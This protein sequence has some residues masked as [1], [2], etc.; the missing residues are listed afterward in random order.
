MKLLLSLLLTIAIVTV[1]ISLSDL[2][3]QISYGQNVLQNFTAPKFGISIQYPVDWTFVENVYEDRDYRPGEP[4][5]YLGELC[6]TASIEMLLG[7]SSCSGLD[8]P[9]SVTIHTFKL[10][11]DTTTKQF[12]DDSIVPLMEASKE[13]VGRKNIE[14]S[15]IDISGLSAIQRVERIGGGNIDKLLEGTGHETTT[16]KAISVYLANG[17]TGYQIFASVDNEED[18]D[19]YLPTIQ[20]M[21]GSVKIE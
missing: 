3:L 15:E 4:R 10:P 6:P 16:S 14:T 12:Y 17:S 1:F 20:K 19:D 8:V 18:Y 2:G 11:E 7:A 9:V 21:M 13:T 5:A